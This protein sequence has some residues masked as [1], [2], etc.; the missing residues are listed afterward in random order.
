MLISMSNERDSINRISYKIEG[1]EWVT[2]SKAIFRCPVCGDSKKDQ[3]KRRGSFFSNGG[4]FMF[5]CFNCDN[6]GNGTTSYRKFLE[7]FDHSEYEYLRL[8]RLRDSLSSLNMSNKPVEQKK[9]HDKVGSI[10]SLF[11]EEKHSIFKTLRS[12]DSLHESHEAREYVRGR[13]IPKKDLSRLYYVHD[14]AQWAI[15]VNPNLMEQD[16]KSGEGIVIPLISP[17][18]TEFGYQC[19]FMQGKFRYM[20][21]IMNQ[22]DIKSFGLDKIDVEKDI[23]VTEGTFDSFYLPNAIASLDGSLHGTCTKLT[24]RYGIPKEKFI[25]WFDFEPGNSQVMK[26]KR[27][28]VEEGYRVAFVRKQDAPFKDINKIIQEADDPIKAHRALR[29]NA[30][31][32][33]GIHARLQFQSTTYM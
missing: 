24:E 17:D 31:I 1:F 20:T 23:N 19:R 28:A 6:D 10:N 15:E 29:E 13:R 11:D 14:F 16:K 12:L 18:G 5:G 27:M 22:T 7:F 8:G 2:S 4:P 9:I 3:N 32:L 26:M 25:L 33:S 21:H 30:V